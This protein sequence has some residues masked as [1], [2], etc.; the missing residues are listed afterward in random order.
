MMDILPQRFE[1]MA[2]STLTPLEQTNVELSRWVAISLPRQTAV[3]ASLE[4]VDRGHRAPL[5][6]LL[7]ELEKAHAKKME[8][9]AYNEYELTWER[10]ILRPLSLHLNELG[11]AWEQQ[12]YSGVALE[13]FTKL[14]K[15]GNE[16]I[17]VFGENK[18]TSSIKNRV[19]A[20]MDAT[21]LDLG[22][23]Q[24]ATPYYP[25]GG[26]RM[27]VS[28]AIW[29]EL[30]NELSPKRNH[31]YYHEGVYGFSGYLDMYRSLAIGLASVLEGHKEKMREAV[32]GDGL[33]PKQLSALDKFVDR[34]DEDDDYKEDRKAKRAFLQA[35][36]L[37][38]TTPATGLAKPKSRRL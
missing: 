29:K 23:P 33:G 14:A 27:E 24:L 3:Q 17:A 9:L 16:I 1:I 20:F 4:T 31:N 26:K 36:K 15:L 7:K 34:V 25:Q 2:K 38:E 28:E 5:R 6:K 19:E 37:A 10:D 13:Y 22:E 18:P 35:Q 32:N 12:S 8:S 21:P 30:L 11:Q